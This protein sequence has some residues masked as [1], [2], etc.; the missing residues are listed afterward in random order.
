MGTGHRSRVETEAESNPGTIAWLWFRTLNDRPRSEPGTGL[1]NR[2]DMGNGAGE[3]LVVGQ[4]Q[5]IV[6][7][8]GSGSELGTRLSSETRTR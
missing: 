2:S 4:D 6:L 1:E 8:Q 5:I 3:R 7:R